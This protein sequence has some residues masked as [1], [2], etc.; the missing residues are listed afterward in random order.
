MSDRGERHFIEP[1]TKLSPE[2]LNPLCNFIIKVQFDRSERGGT[3]YRVPK[4]R[5]RMQRLAGRTRPGIHYLCPTNA[6][7]HGKSAGHSFSE[8]EQ[9][10]INT[11]LITGEKHP[12]SIE[13]GINLVENK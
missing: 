9:V 8:T 4:K 2:R 3:A 5:R 6:S 12:G 10:R 11:E 7:G 13:P 1:F